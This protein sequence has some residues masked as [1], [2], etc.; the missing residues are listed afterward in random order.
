MTRYA[1]VCNCLTFYL[2][3]TLR[4]LSHVVGTDNVILLGA[5]DTVKLAAEIG[6]EHVNIDE[7]SK[8]V[9]MRINGLERVF[10]NNGGNKDRFEKF[11]FYRFFFLEHLMRNKGIDDLVHL[12]ADILLY[13]FPDI[14]TAVAD[15]SVPNE[16]GTFLSR[17]TLE[18][19]SKFNDFV[20]GDYFLDE[21]R[22][23]YCD[24]NA[25]LHFIRQEC[26]RN[27]LTIRISGERGYEG[28]PRADYSF[29]HFLIDG[30]FNNLNNGTGIEIETVERLPLIQ[31]SDFLDICHISEE[32][33]T[34]N[35][36]NLKMVH[37]QGDCKRYFAHFSR[38][39]FKREMR[40]K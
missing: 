30:Y 13:G 31:E 18:A 33:V 7:I 37:L 8:D 34:I 9:S 25:L 32:G 24:M 1:I 11:C 38:V 12:D 10:K 36:R 20:V 5:P 39:E 6:V 2:P 22:G 16:S 28:C 14:S 21:N 29:R 4:N 27:G 26:P 3:T 40:F 15:L 23:R 17:W 19:L 35:N